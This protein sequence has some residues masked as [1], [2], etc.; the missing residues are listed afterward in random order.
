M[1]TNNIRM[2]VQVCEN[3]IK[4][5]DRFY[6]VCLSCTMNLLCIPKNVSMDV[7]MCEGKDSGDDRFY[8]CLSYTMILCFQV[9]TSWTL[10]YA[11]KDSRVMMIILLS[12]CVFK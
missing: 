2:D 3:R 12:F 8:Y 10:K 6:D 11:G 9:T 1:V 7:Q 4:S 5:D